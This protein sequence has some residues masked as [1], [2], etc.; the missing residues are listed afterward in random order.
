MLKI[1]IL[2]SFKCLKW[3]QELV[4]Y[5]N[6]K[7]RKSS[8]S[9]CHSLALVNIKCSLYSLM[10]FA[11]CVVFCAMALLMSPSNVFACGFVEAPCY[12]FHKD[13]AIQK[14]LQEVNKMLSY[15]R[16]CWGKGFGLLMGMACR[17][18]S[19]WAVASSRIEPNEPNRIDM[20]KRFVLI[21]DQ[22]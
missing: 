9:S 8:S 19:R 18:R 7:E 2:L 14:Y 5:R 11:G 22:S 6:S 1:F 4:V 20:S 10:G 17:R 16:R 12:A 13:S 21:Q 15:L 3:L